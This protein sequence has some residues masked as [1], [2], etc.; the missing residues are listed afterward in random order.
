MMPESNSLLP[1]HVA[2]RS[3]EER[4]R[5]TAGERHLELACRCMVE[6]IDGSDAGSGWE[7]VAVPG[8]LL[9]WRA[10]ETC[11]EE[12]LLLVEADSHGISLR[13]RVRG[14]G[15]L[16]TVVFGAGNERGFPAEVGSTLGHLTWVRRDPVRSWTGSPLAHARVFN[17]QP[18]G[19][20]EQELPAAC[21]QRVTCATTFGPER[22]NT[23]FAPSLAAYVID[24]AWCI[25]LVAQRG[26]A[27]FTHFDYQVGNGWGLVLHFDGQTEIDGE[28]TSP[29]IRIAPC[30]GVDDGLRELVSY[31]R[32]AGAAPA[33]GSPPPAWIRRPMLC[34]WGQQTAWT[35]LAESGSGLPLGSPVTPGAQGF[36]S[37]EGCREIVRLAEAA[38]LPFGV[39]TID[40]GWS[41]CQCVP[42]P[43][44]RLWSDLKGFIAE[45]HAK[46]RKVLLWLATWNV[47]GLPER[48]RMAHDMGLRDVA[49]PTHPE[50]RQRL[51]AAIH[52]C[53]SPDGLD[54]DGF[55]LDY[56]GDM[57][58]GVGYRPAVP[59]RWG[60]DLIRDYVGLIHDAMKFV[61]SDAVLQTH[62]ASPY[63]ADLTEC[64]RLNDIFSPRK[65]IV[66][67]MAFRAR[68][69]AI[70]NPEAAIDCDCDPFSDH[71]AW[72]EYVRHQ[73]RIGVPS[74][75]SL[76]HLGF[77]GPDGRL[78]RITAAD[79]AEIAAIWHRYLAQLP[80]QMAAT[81]DQVRSSEPTETTLVVA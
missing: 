60:L 43:D 37:E 1:V 77:P 63:L 44:C 68:M 13:I 59:G 36:A 75:Y 67:M 76:T 62:C 50:F 57:P 46:G 35:Q 71:A 72:L 23:F 42:E 25:G 47:I 73:P 38:G 29:A 41:A 61:K 24:D 4:I 26:A 39:L 52:A 9:A 14:R 48:W 49:D 20:G 79:L 65:D 11:W 78:S 6:P 2:Y 74:L 80:D 56:T 18:D 17:P 27:G 21:A 7:P 30:H 12:K 34:T 15:R 55:K 19:Y 64:L 69:A 3:A 40:A 8:A 31:L 70:A 66:A 58:R 28:W 53:I 33:V 54:A 5:I 22:F 16:S 32:A 81:V 10:R 45:Q 51:A